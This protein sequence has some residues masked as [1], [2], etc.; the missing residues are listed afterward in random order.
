MCAFKNF[1]YMKILYIGALLFVCMLTGCQKN[2]RDIAKQ[3][4][5]I[6]TEES[7]QG[8]ELKAMLGVEDIWDETIEAEARTGEKATVKISAKV[9]LPSTDHMSV[10]QLESDGF[11]QEKRQEILEAICEPDSISNEKPLEAVKAELEQYVEL[12]DRWQQKQSDTI[13]TYG[14]RDESIDEILN[15]LYSTQKT[16]LN[17]MEENKAENRQT[18]YTENEFYGKIDGRWFHFCFTNGNLSAGLV[19]THTR[20]LSFPLPENQYC[21]YYYVRPEE[22]E[23][24][25]NQCRISRTEAEQIADDFLEKMGYKEYMLNDCQNIRWAA[26]DVNQLDLESYSYINKN[27]TELGDCG[28]YF[29]YGRDVNGVAADVS[30]YAY[31]TYNIENYEAYAVGK[32]GVER[33]EVN[34]DNAGIF[35]FHITYP[36]K[37]KAVLEQQVKLLSFAQIQDAFRSAIKNSTEPYVQNAKQV[38]CFDR[39]ELVYFRHLCD[40]GTFTLLPVWRLCS[41]H[42]GDVE[43]PER[44]AAVYMV[45]AIDGTSIDVFDELYEAANYVN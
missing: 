42:Q 37:Q 33:V 35:A 38:S 5:S 31:I 43:E 18:D 2:E 14:V 16:L 17:S 44:I 7:A 30:D 12:I 4:G 11:T 29:T 32:Y 22:A 6:E 27:L 19:N 40:D 41:L 8:A 39:L 10:V 1:R 26:L 25:E 3:V 34:I 28:W 36:Y 9:F 15:N 13:E 21:E 24:I 20:E 23:G 45:N